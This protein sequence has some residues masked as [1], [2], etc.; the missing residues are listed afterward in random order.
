MPHDDLLWPLRP[1]A[2]QCDVGSGGSLQASPRGDCAI[3]EL[4]HT[5][6]PVLATQHLTS[7]PI[8]EEG[9]TVVN[10]AVANTFW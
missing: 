6:S 7:M 10:H 8:E 4:S 5:T 2:P 3:C 1:V 9:R